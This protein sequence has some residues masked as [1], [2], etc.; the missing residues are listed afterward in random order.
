MSSSIGM[1]GP[2]E[3][4]SGVSVVTAPMMPIFWPPTSRPRD[5]L[6]RSPTLDAALACDVG[7][8]DRELDHVEERRQRVLAVVELVVADGHGVELHLVQ[9]LGFGLA[10]VGRVEERALEIVAAV[11]QQH[12]LAVELLALV[13]RSP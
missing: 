10:L 8:Q 3:A 1:L 2:G 7:R 5:G 9:E 11:Q 13:R 6:M 4:I 12:V